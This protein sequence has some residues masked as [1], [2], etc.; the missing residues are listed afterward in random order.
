MQCLTYVVENRRIDVFK[1]CG[2]EAAEIIETVEFVDLRC[3]QNAWSDL[4]LTDM[5]QQQ[6]LPQLVLRAR[7][8]VFLFDNMQKS[9][10]VFCG[11]KS[12]AS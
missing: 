8:V 6:F 12:G 1:E 7:T 9:S 3:P 2:I 10:S 4:E 11:K 5:I